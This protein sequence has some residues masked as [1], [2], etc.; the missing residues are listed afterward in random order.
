MFR[1]QEGEVEACLDHRKIGGCE[2]M[3]MINLR[4]LVFLCTVLSSCLY[5]HVISMILGFNL[6]WFIGTSV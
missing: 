5:L 2:K 4:K 3:L 1:S 6:E